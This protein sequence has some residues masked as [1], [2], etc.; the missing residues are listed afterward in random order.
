MIKVGDR[1]PE[2]T[3]RIK[4]DQ[5]TVNKVSSGE[6]F[7][8]KRVVV[9]GVPGAFTS[10]CHKAHVPTFIAA[11]GD[12]KAKGV[13]EVVVLA[14]NDH[15]VMRAWADSYGN[16]AGVLF[17]ADGSTEF[18]NMIGLVHDATGAG[19]GTRYDRFSMLVEDGTVKQLN[20]ETDH[21]K[22]AVSG[23]ATILGQL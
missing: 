10:T 16:P 9:V 8:G 21:G 6:L 12:L 18:G 11:I 5:G 14:N 4:D 2:A 13:D 17:V 15:H 23:A 7:A 19:M 1:L 3:L 20:R 22:V